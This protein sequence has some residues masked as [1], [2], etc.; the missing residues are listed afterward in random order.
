MRFLPS[1]LR[2]E[3]EDE[4]LGDNDEQGRACEVAQHDRARAFAAIASARRRKPLAEQLDAYK[5]E[6]EIQGVILVLGNT[7][8]R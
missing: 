8:F 4:D 1:F 7:L 5:P 6:L 2:S 3:T